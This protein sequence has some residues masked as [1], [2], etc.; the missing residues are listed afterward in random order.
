MVRQTEKEKRRGCLVLT[1]KAARNGCKEASFL[2]ATQEQYWSDGKA[3]SSNEENVSIQV[4]WSN[5]RGNS[6]NKLT[7]QVIC[8]I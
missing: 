5:F 8:Q 4:S 1:K 7:S 2:R 3:I 6:D